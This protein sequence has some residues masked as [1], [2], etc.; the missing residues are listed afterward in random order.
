MVKSRNQWNWKWKNNRE[1]SVKL[2]AHFWKDFL[3]IDKHVAGFSKKQTRLKF[4]EPEM[5]EETLL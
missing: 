2:K 4:Q 5:R 3:K 1:K